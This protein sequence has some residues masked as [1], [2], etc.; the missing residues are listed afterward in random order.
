MLSAS[1]PHQPERSAAQSK[2][3]RR[4]TI[5]ASVACANFLRL[6]DDLRAL[7]AAGVDYLHIDIMDGQFV[8]NFCL[9]TDIM[10]AARQVTACRWTFT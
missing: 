2:A 5:A 7:E 8:P 3:A 4:V 10:K 1:T 9:N 6:E